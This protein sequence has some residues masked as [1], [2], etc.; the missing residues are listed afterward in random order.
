MKNKYFNFFKNKKGFLN[1]PLLIILI[2][3]F[4]LVPVKATKAQVIANVITDIQQQFSDLWTN[5]RDT[6]KTTLKK[7][8][9]VALNT[10]IRNTLNRLAYDAAEDLFAGGEGQK[11]KIV[12]KNWGEYARDIGDAAAGD[13]LDTLNT[14]EGINLCEPSLDI[15][16]NIGLGLDRQQRPREPNCTMSKMTQA[17]GDELDRIKDMQSENFLQEFYGFLEPE[18]NSLS[19]SLELM[20]GMEFKERTSTE[21]A[22][23]YL[24]ATK[25][26]D[27][28]AISD[29]GGQKK[30]LPGSSQKDVEAAEEQIKNSIGKTTGDA[31]VDAAN[32]FLNQLALKAYEKG[33]QMVMNRGANS[34]EEEEGTPS[35]ISEALS[36]PDSDSSY[37]SSQVKAEL[38]KVIEP[39]FDVQGDFDVLAKLSSCPSFNTG[40]NVLQSAD[41]CVMD[42][43]FRQAVSE[44]KTV[45]EA[46][47]EGYLK[48]DWI[49]T[50]VDQKADFNESYTYRSIMI[51]RKY[52]IVPLGW[53]EAVLR[54]H[55][56]GQV[57]TLQDLVSCYAVDDEYNTFS[58]NFP[59]NASWCRGLVDPNWVLKAPLNYCAKSGYGYVLSK[60][61]IEGFGEGENRMPSSFHVARVDDYCA[62]SKTCIK[63]KSDGSCEAYGYCTEEERTW[64][65]EEDSCEPVFNTCETFKDKESGKTVSYL[66]NTLDYSNCNA[67]SVGCQGYSTS[68]VYMQEDDVIDWKNNELIYLKNTTDCQES[69]ENCDQLVSIKPGYGH[70]FVRN[71]SFDLVEEKDQ[72][73]SKYCNSNSSQYVENCLSEDGYISEYSADLSKFN[74]DEVNIEVGPSD[75]NI[76]GNSYFLSFYAKGCSENDTFGFLDE[77]GSVYNEVNLLEDD[78]WNY[79][80]IF[81]AYLDDRYLGNEVS[82]YIDSNSCKIDNLK[83]EMGEKATRYTEFGSSNLVYQKMIPEYL[84]SV[85]YTNPFS[86]SKNFTLKEDA[87]DICRNFAR[88]CNED[89]VGCETYTELDN[90]SNTVTAKVS[91]QDK[92]DEDCNNYDIYAQKDDYFSSS[93]IEKF[94]PETAETCSASAVGCNEFTNLDELNQGAENREYYKTIRQCVVPDGNSCENFYTWQG[95]GSGSPQLVSF[96]LEINT[97]L[98][99]GQ[100]NNGGKL[101]LTESDSGLCSKEIFKLPPSHPDY[102]PDCYEFYDE[103]GNISYHLYSR[104]ITCSN[105]CHPYRLTEKNV[106]YSITEEIKCSGSDKHWDEDAEVCYYCKNNGSWNDEYNACVYDAIPGLGETCSANDYGCKEYD[107]SKGNN[108]RIVSADSFNNQFLS[109]W[110]VGVCF[111]AL[112]LSGESLNK[113]GSS[114]YFDSNIEVCGEST[115]KREDNEDSKEGFVKRFFG[116]IAKADLTDDNM[117][118]SKTFG[119]IIENGNA[120]SLKF[121]AKSVNN[122]ELKVY[123]EN[124]AGEESVFNSIEDSNDTLTISGDD[125]WHVYEVVLDNISH[126]VDSEEELV[127]K[128]VS[129]SLSQK[130]TIYLDDIILTEIIDK[131]YLIQNSWETPDICYYDV[132]DNYRGSN[133]NLGCSA[134]SDRFGNTEYLREFS[135]LCQDSA[136]GCQL[137]L[138]TKNSTDEYNGKIYHDVDD[139]G[140][141]GEEESG[142]FQTEADEY[143]YAVY[144]SNY[145]C[146]RQDKG[147]ERLGKIND[148]GEK[149]IF[150]DVYVINDPDY[151]DFNLCKE[152]SLDC[153]AWTNASGLEVFFKDPGEKLCEWRQSSNGGDWAWYK[154]TNKKCDINNNGEAEEFENTC[155]SSSDCYIS[156]AYYED[157][158]G[159]CSQNEDC[160]LNVCNEDTSTCSLTGNVCTNNDSCE[161]TNICVSGYCANSCIGNEGDYP[162]EVTSENTL[163]YG[164]VNGEVYQPINSWVGECSAS[165]ST[166]TELIDPVSSYVVNEVVNP[167]FS[168]LNSDGEIGDYW[169]GEDNQDNYQE[170]KFITNK[171][172]TFGVE[173]EDNKLSNEESLAW[174]D[175]V[176]QN[177]YIVSVIKPISSNN[178]FSS[179]AGQGTQNYKTFAINNTNQHRVFMYRDDLLGI[180]KE[181]ITCRV[182]R[183]KDNNIDDYSVIV[184]EAIIDYQL[185]NTLDNTSC[186]GKTSL[187]NGCVMF[188]KRSYTSSGYSGLG[189]SAQ[190]SYISNTKSPQMEEINNYKNSNTLIKVKPDRVCGSWL[191]C[192]TFVYDENGKTYCYDVAEC[193]LLDKDGNCANYIEG[194]NGVRKFQTSRDQNASGYS[195]VG[196]YYLSDMHEA[197]SNVL[198]QDFEDSA[199]IFS[200][201][202]GS[203]GSSWIIDEP[204]AESGDK[205]INV[206]YPAEGGNFLKVQASAILETD[207]ISIQKKQ[208]YVL[209]YLLNSSSLGAGDRAKIEI[210]GVDDNGVV[211]ETPINSF[212]YKTTGWE[213]KVY[214]FK[215]TI[216][217]TIRIRISSKVGSGSHFFYIDDVNIETAL[218]YTER[219]G[220]TEYISKTCR[221]FPKQDS[222]SCKSVAQS[223]I[224]NGWQGY[225]LQE[226][227][228][229]PGVCLMWYPVDVIGTQLEGEGKNSGYQGKTN[230]WY[231][232]EAN[233]DFTIA[234]RRVGFNNESGEEKTT[235]ANVDE[236]KIGKVLACYHEDGE[237][238]YCKNKLGCY[239]DGNVE[240]HDTWFVYTN[241]RKYCN[242]FLASQGCEK[243]KGRRCTCF[244]GIGD[245]YG[246]ISEV[247]Y[248]QSIENKDVVQENCGDADNYIYVANVRYSNPSG[249]LNKRNVGN[250]FCAPIEE[251]KLGGAF[252]YYNNTLS[253]KDENN[254]DTSE[255]LGGRNGWYKYNDDLTVMEAYRE[256]SLGFTDSDPVFK[257]Y[258]GKNWDN[259]EYYKIKC[260]ELTQVVTSVGE[261]K[262][263]ALRTSPSTQDE[264]LSFFNV[265]LNGYIYNREDLPFGSAIIDD[266]DFSGEGLYFKTISS[267]SISGNYE[268][269][270]A[271]LPYGCE[272]SSCGYL[273]YCSNEPEFLCLTNLEDKTYNDFDQCEGK[274]VC[275]SFLSDVDTQWEELSDDNF[276]KNIFLKSYQIKNYDSNGWTINNNNF[277]YTD[278]SL[279]NNSLK[280]CGETNNNNLRGENSNE[281]C[282]VY[283]E[284]E[285][286]ILKKGNED[287]ELNLSNEYEMKGDGIYSLYF[288]TIV[289]AEQTPLGDIVISWG[290]G[291][292]QTITD[293]D[294]HPDEEY[295]HMI[296]HSYKNVSD[297]IEIKIKIFDNWGFGRCCSGSDS[298]CGGP[299]SNDLCP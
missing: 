289:D 172:Y 110:E 124:E 29:V 260:N 291:N 50:G 157:G 52:R 31:L 43:D 173:S 30:D 5:I 76:S 118:I 255:D 61:V 170:I 64:N 125:A 86:G 62:D 80:R 108:T 57:T 155:N 189:Y 193:D 32:V 160:R 71:G 213:R 284:I 140:T 128:I 259:L 94:I 88:R 127:L 278:L 280:W 224:S 26:E 141:C 292:T 197:G 16:A 192:E 177:G 295:P 36:D 96:N 85:C 196:S 45:G 205:V 60:E 23:D 38:K 227:P 272:G 195:M 25:G 3:S 279:D 168:D 20:Q 241:N 102:N 251:N 12:T 220:K 221:L 91:I 14:W 69:S 230:R 13:F 49:F 105:N 41:N 236:N 269:N 164:G 75:Y 92:C 264:T 257:I 48:K 145:S 28:S 296:S 158:N 9:S 17:W 150:S 167:S 186:N 275:Q 208:V 39:R 287:V 89:E 8:A 67:D 98:N 201:I 225:C 137:M 42:Q 63:E 232:T 238:L 215:T 33:L 121:L 100:I 70:N 143:I 266:F 72:W 113:D 74:L 293:Q 129:P 51:L 276:L 184:K 65:F 242:D 130:P 111:N 90:L 200:E 135:S 103:D 82:F 116:K 148:V 22:K 223:V 6:A 256:N 262:A 1:K 206:D 104:T 297:S 35:W 83:L 21:D 123:F 212:S 211:G 234:E 235:W 154:K 179:V 299:D 151:Y 47:D 190:Q 218:A 34:S 136:V 54:A 237:G 202:E 282:Y 171:T 263:W 252:S 290:D 84:W 271:G 228:Y 244:Y 294:F 249:G 147:C 217:D 131:Y 183:N 146:A 253:C 185:A 174:I 156:G 203:T 267:Y 199:N 246:S 188:N 107:G 142:C 182:Y 93:K 214:E 204:L 194:N 226:D 53:E 68:G 159:S 233:G 181:N 27:E 106:D 4:L 99:Q 178:N 138:D 166:C 87:P 216:Y 248:E 261:N 119:R 97:G 11:P 163:G 132:L 122:I 243:D 126:I 133:Y 162:C 250:F 209:N 15:K 81:R 175:C 56:E 73:G 46:L 268:N 288:N 270:F 40:Q 176:D 298:N 258:E 24:L 109:D 19:V 207:N 285:N 165:A 283:P 240:E 44:K 95:S 37:G 79:Y 273:G 149:D 153:K 180:N 231:C 78:D 66:K 254:I 134:Y 139:D 114:M 239:K 77:D 229:Y 58:N 222:L 144:D 198:K 117:K 18:G 265:N 112:K 152:N 286:I 169:E 10:A 245:A 115:T 247:T 187:N 161:N 210:Y 219:N 277:D 120:Y 274:G 55:D 101:K 191:A 281:F 59:S 7:S 2:I